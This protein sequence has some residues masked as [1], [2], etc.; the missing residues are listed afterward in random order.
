MRSVKVLPRDRF[1]ESRGRVAV[2]QTRDPVGVYVAVA[3][4]NVPATTD[5]PAPPP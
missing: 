4:A 3:L 2:A 5:E 1:C